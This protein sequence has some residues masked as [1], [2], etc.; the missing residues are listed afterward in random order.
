MNWK[1]GGRE[2][3]RNLIWGN[4]PAFAWEDWWKTRK[5]STRRAK[6]RADFP[7]TNKR[8][9]ETSFRN[10]AV[11][12]TSNICLLT[13]F[14]TLSSRVSHSPLPP[15]AHIY[16]VYWSLLSLL[17][18]SHVLHPAGYCSG[19]AKKLLRKLSRE[20]HQTSRGFVR[21][22]SVSLRRMAEQDFQQATTISFT[23]LMSVP[24][25]GFQPHAKAAYRKLFVT[26]FNTSFK[27]KV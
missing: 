12:G 23:F 3:H 16:I 2:N 15:S 1:R 10:D 24:L 11:N 25:I 20:V 21:N 13:E 5:P 7:H 26:A 9:T 22:S 6:A 17:Y 18:I 4:T 8:T 14:H 27:W 19:N